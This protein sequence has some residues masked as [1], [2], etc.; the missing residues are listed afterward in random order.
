MSR[1]RLVKLGS[2]LIVFATL[3]LV[4]S[5]L[6]A[7]EDNPWIYLRDFEFV[8]G[9]VSPVQG[10]YIATMLRNT[11]KGLLALVIY[12]G[13]CRAGDCIVGSPTAFIAVDSPGRIVKLHI[14]P[15]MKLESIILGFQT[16]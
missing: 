9:A 4:R 15:G 13:E 7:Q 10:G 2:A 16:S 12:P 6:H 14:E 8:E 5:P 3:L 11:A 1:A